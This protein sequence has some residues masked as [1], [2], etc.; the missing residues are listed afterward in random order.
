MFTR[1]SLIAACAAMVAV[2]AHVPARASSWRN[3]TYVTFN[4][5]VALPGITLAPGT[6]V[7]ERTLI[8]NPHVVQVRSR[9]RSRV[10]LVALTNRVIRPAGLPASR[11]IVLGEVP[12]GGIPPVLAWYPADRE[13]GH[14]FVYP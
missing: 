4:V 7:F 10:Y 5:S 3:T 11:H 1:A 13:A 2:A 12:S 6:Y 14:A 8:D 9:D